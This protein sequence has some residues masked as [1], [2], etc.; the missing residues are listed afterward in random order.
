[1]SPAIQLDAI[2]DSDPVHKRARQ[3][4]LFHLENPLTLRFGNDFFRSLAE[5]PGVYFFHGSDGCLLYIG[6]SLN[7][8]SRLGSYRHVDRSRQPRRTLR[9]VSRVTRVEWKTCTSAD[10]AIETERVLL[11]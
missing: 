9:L 10:E 1:M 7:L 4:K 5:C 6:Q 3:L 8:R 11:P 2:L